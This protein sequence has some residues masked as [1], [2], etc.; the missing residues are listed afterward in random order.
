MQVQ[1]YLSFEGR[2]EEAIEFY[3]K[4]VGAKVTMMMRNKESPEQH[5]GMPPNS[6]DKIMHS[7]MTI[8]DSVV[9]ATDGAMSGK[10]NFAGISLSLNV[11]SD[12]EAKKLFNNLA[13]GGKVTLPLSKTFF[14][15]SFGMVADKFG[16]HW[17]V[18]AGPSNP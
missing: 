7:A 9:M 1:P 5:P 11:D 17:M 3:K 15:S 4:A 16:V 6:G 14:A 10:P 12:A 13:D 2:A 18:M 8:G